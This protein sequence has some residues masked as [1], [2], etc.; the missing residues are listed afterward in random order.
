MSASHK[1]KKFLPIPYPASPALAP[2]SSGSGRERPGT[3]VVDASPSTPYAF[4]LHNLITQSGK[5]N[6]QLH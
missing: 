1:Y 5:N 6:A 4:Q 3:H 2:W